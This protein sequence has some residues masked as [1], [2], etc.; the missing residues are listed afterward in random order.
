MSAY[1]ISEKFGLP[2]KVAEAIVD[3]I[4][5]IFLKPTSG[6][7]ITRTKPKSIKSCGLLW[8]NKAFSR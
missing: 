3:R 7:K 2:I 8:Q 5:N 4:K 1:G 6:L